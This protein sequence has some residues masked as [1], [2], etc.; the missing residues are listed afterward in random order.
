MTAL[1]GMDLS[2]GLRALRDTRRE[3]WWFAR[4]MFLCAG[5]QAAAPWLRFQPSGGPDVAPAPNPGRAAVFG[6]RADREMREWAARHGAI[7]AMPAPDLALRIGEKT[8]LPE[9]AHAAGVAVPRSV[10][11]RSVRPADAETMWR[12]LGATRAV[13]QL[14]DNDLTGAGTW[15][16]D[17][18]DEL[19]ACLAAWAG[20]GVKLARFLDGLP[21]TVSAVVTGASVVVSGISYQLVGHP[22]PSCPR[23]PATRRGK[24]AG[25][26]EWHSVASASAACSALTRS[27]PKTVWSCSR[28][29]PGCR[30]SPPS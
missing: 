3:P 17:D 18:V 13:A 30:A 22:T 28:S 16:V 1:A 4:S 26:W 14:A 12:E 19:G 27:S 8:R 7:V 9:I 25:G 23:A 21:I 10:I 29:I 5:C 2:H 15:R 20:R 6:F 24:R 11:R